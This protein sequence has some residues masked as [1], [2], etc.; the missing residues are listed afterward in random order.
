MSG[1]FYLLE[2]LAGNTSYMLAPNPENGP[3]IVTVSGR[4]VVNPAWR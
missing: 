1:W 2:P 3:A 4:F